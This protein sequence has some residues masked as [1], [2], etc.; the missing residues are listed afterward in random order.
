MYLTCQREYL[1]LKNKFLQE[2][3][4]PIGKAISCKIVLIS[5]RNKGCFPIGIKIPIGFER[6]RISLSPIGN[7]NFM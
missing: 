4:I 3:Y 6:K 1:P 5:Y 7:I 2:N